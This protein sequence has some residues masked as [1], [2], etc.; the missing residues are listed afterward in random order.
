LEHENF[1][2]VL[3]HAWQLSVLSNDSA[4]RISAKFKNLRR[5][6][7]AWKAQLP[8]LAS[9]IQNFKDLIQF[10]D[11]LVENRDLTLQ[12]WNFRNAISRHLEKL[13]HQQRVYWK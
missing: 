8:N 7:K 2:P 10:L 4:K 1:I 5:V 12:E 6:L 13:L 9:A 11:V 3:Q